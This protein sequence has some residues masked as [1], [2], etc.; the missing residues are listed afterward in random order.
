[1][2]DVN[3]TIRFDGEGGGRG[4]E[5]LPS[6]RDYVRVLGRRK[7]IILLVGLLVPLAAV[8]ASLTQERLYQAS[9]E[10][11]VSRQNLAADLTG[12]T[13]GNP[14]VSGDPERLVQTQA[15]L[16]SVPTVAQRVLAAT[17][18]RDRTPEDFLEDSTVAPRPD[19]D[20]LE[21]RV[22]DRDPGL[23]V[24]LA[25]AYAREFTEYRRE[26]DT[27]ALTEAQSAIREELAE[28]EE[29]GGRDSA[30]YAELISKEQQL[31][32]LQSLQ[33]GNAFVVR[34][35]H[36]A[37][38][39][40]PQPVRNGIL[41]LGVGLIL[42]VVLA[43]LWEGLDTRVR[44]AEEIAERLGLP[45]LARIP[46]PSRRRRGQVQL[47]ML[48]DPNGQEAEAYR[49]LRTSLG[50]G[51]P[52]HG[53]RV[54]MMTS[55]L[56][57]EGKST[58][59]ANLAVAFAR[60][61]R[62]VITVDADLRH[63]T[64]HRFF[65]LEPKPGLT[66]VVVGRVG[67]DDA[68]AEVALP[69][70]ENAVSERDGNGHHDVLGVLQVLPCGASTRDVGELIGS[71]ALVDV[72]QE[73]RCRADLV[74]VDAPAFLPNSDGLM[75][76]ANVDALLVVTRLNVVGKPMLD[77]LRRLLEIAPSTKLGFVVTGAD[78]EEAYSYG[79]DYSQMERAPQKS[80]LRGRGR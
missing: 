46:T 22:T 32:T 33:T 80:L 44:S 64:L 8:L 13:G 30:L 6:I 21:F 40:Q 7:R 12:V 16:A 41:G 47:S 45:L 27:A 72:L 60:A 39:V 71:Q 11:F 4:S 56:P 75:L 14:N 19:A 20:V 36:E 5:E 50:L 52:L 65:Q 42:G 28:L 24:R 63:P 55:A 34:S 26:L 1:M 59:L 38:Q 10:V 78:A 18:V 74:L 43:F 37:E 68:L 53:A 2:R 76:T 62:R 49:V 54:V 79:V 70:L 25:T 9:A 3:D 31:R 61:G 23:A 29:S 48:A 66:D 69:S 17:D 67:L 15:A 77:E 73:L 51:E 35:A 58:T 57:D